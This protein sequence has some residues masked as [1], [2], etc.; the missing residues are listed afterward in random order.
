[1]TAD[2]SKSSRRTTNT[3]CACL[4]YGACSMSMVLGNKALATYRVDLHLLPVLL[5]CLM[6]V[7]MVTVL[8]SFDLPG[9][10]PEGLKLRT[11][12][13]WLPVNIFFCAMLFTS[14]M[15]LKFINVPLFQ[16]FKT[17]N[18]VLVT[19]G[20]FILWGR[21]VSVSCCGA[22][23]L[24]VTAATVAGLSAEN[25]AIRSGWGMFWMMANIVCTASYILSMRFATN[26]IKLSRFG[27]VKYN[28]TLGVL[29]LLPVVLGKGEINTLLDSEALTSWRYAILNIF[30]GIVGFGINL[31]ALWCIEITSATTYSITGNL[32][33]IPAAVFAWGI[34]GSSISHKGGLCIAINL[35]GGMM[36][37]MA[38]TKK[39]EP[40]AEAKALEK[41]H[42]LESGTPLT[43][44]DSDIE[45]DL[46]DT[47][48][49]S[50]S[51]STK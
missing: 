42:E 15:A 8:G 37:A 45:A 40:K 44:S 34:F 28:N 4:A 1:M 46:A 13:M 25:I 49:I 18:M 38:R 39:P 7:I 47:D 11:A 30:V 36:Y 14:F 23:G 24:M 31:T 10:R 41:G 43:A 27:M 9:V 5:Q 22:L 51:S 33:K 29:L 50:H 6:A 16:M 35:A 20:E 12:L 21:H 26:N 32:S 48:T 17:L 2:T 19:L 3:V